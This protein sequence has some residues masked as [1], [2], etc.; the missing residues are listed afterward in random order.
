MNTV[1]IIGGGPAGYVAAIAAA[2]RGQRVI[3]IEEKQLGGTCLNE[4]CIPTKS[5]LESAE[6][7]EKVKRAALFGIDLPEAEVA[8]NWNGVQDYKRQVM[9]KLVQGVGYLMKKN[10]IEVIQGKASFR[11]DRLLQVEKQDGEVQIEAD[12]VIIAAGSEPI[13]LPFAPFDGE[14]VIHSGHAMSLPEVPASLLIVGGGVIGCEFASIYSRLG[15]KVTIVEMAEHILPGEDPDIAAVLQKQLAAFGVTIYT[16]AA[17]QELQTETK[18]AFVQNGD[19]VEEIRAEYVL[20]S[21][22]RKP[23]LQELGLDRI[24]VQYDRHGIQVNDSMQ[25]SIP[26]IYACGD[27]VGGVQLAHVAFH[28]GETAALHASGIDRKVSYHAVPRCIYTWPEVAGVGLTERQARDQYGEIQ[29]GE[30]SFSANGKALILHEAIGKVKVIVEPVYQQ[31]VG[32]TIVGPRATELIG[33]GSVMLHT[34]LTADTMEGFIAA[35]PTL[36]EAVWEA[37]QNAIVQA[38]HG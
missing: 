33:Q 11:S 29:I 34:E 31:I 8:V 6:T 13:Q 27:V 32:M 37:L 14:W 9:K 19:G 10:Q 25:T 2:R 17:L 4:G 5:L 22:G 24:G 12:R 21:V 18:T 38:L 3:L 30:F 1:G 20:V 35:H 7:Y 26:H 23:R 16:Q 36:S 15:T 28:E